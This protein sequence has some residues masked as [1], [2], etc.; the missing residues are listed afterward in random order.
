MKAVTFYFKNMN[1]TQ[2]LHRFALLFLTF[3]VDLTFSKMMNMQE[4]SQKVN[5]LYSYSSHAKSSISAN[6]QFSAL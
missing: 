6:A 1:P 5:Y 2:S 4:E 3:M